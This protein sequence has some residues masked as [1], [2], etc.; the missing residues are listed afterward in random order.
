MLS[1]VRDTILSAKRKQVD[2]VQPLK[3]GALQLYLD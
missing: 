1:F 3:S 2:A